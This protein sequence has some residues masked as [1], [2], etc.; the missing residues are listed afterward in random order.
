VYDADGGPIGEARYVLGRLLGT[1]HCALCDVTHTPVRRKPAWDAMVTSLGVP[2]TL[3]HL[4]ELSPDV[5]EQ[6]SAHGAPLLLGRDRG[7]A[8][9][10][11]LDPPALDA[12]GGSVERFESAVRACLAP[13]GTLTARPGAP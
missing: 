7:G 10:V 5:A 2:V 13:G 12:L 3:L 4:N 1:A 6:V 8:L 9:H 11:L